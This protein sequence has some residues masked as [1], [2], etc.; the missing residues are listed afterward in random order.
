[1]RVSIV[2]LATVAPDT[3]ETDGLRDAVT[4][5]RHADALGFH[6]RVCRAPPVVGEPRP[7]RVL[8]VSRA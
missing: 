7:C 3:S 5:V 4:T 2:E 8:P 6:A 1:M